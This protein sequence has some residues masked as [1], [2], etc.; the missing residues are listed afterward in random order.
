[1]VAGLLW[2]QRLS[3]SMHRP[4]QECPHVT[5]SGFDLSSAGNQVADDLFYP[6]SGAPLC[7]P[8]HAV[9]VMD[10]VDHTD[11]DVLTLVCLRNGMVLDLHRCYGLVEVLVRPADMDGIPFLDVP[12]EDNSGD[13]DLRVVMDHFSNHGFHRFKTSCTELIPGLAP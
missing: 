2:Q 13:T 4:D 10:A 8:E 11:A 1:M 7:S 6:P 3:G 12:L 9:T 5:E